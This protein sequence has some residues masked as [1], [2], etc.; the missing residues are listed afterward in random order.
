ML[1]KHKSVKHEKCFDV[2]KSGVDITRFIEKKKSTEREIPR[3]VNMSVSKDLKII[4]ERIEKEENDKTEP[5]VEIKQ[6]FSKVT[7]ANLQS[8]STIDKFVEYEQAL[9]KIK[10]HG[11]KTRIIARTE[12][13]E[14]EQVL[15]G[16]VIDKDMNNKEIQSNSPVPERQSSLLQSLMQNVHDVSVNEKC[17]ENISESSAEEPQNQN[18]VRQFDA[19]KDRLIDMREDLALTNK[20]ET[21][22]NK[23]MS[24]KTS[25]GLAKC[26]LLSLVFDEELPDFGYLE[27]EETPDKKKASKRSYSRRKVIAPKKLPPSKMM[28]SPR[29]TGLHKMGAS[30]FDI[31]AEKETREKVESVFKEFD[32]NEEEIKLQARKNLHA[33]SVTVTCIPFSEVEKYARGGID[34]KEISSLN[35]MPQIH[36]DSKKMGSELKAFPR[37][38]VRSYKNDLIS[39]NDDKSKISGNEDVRKDLTGCSIISESAPKNT[40]IIFKST[41]KNSSVVSENAPRN[42]PKKTLQRSSEQN[43][44][45]DKFYTAVFQDPG[46]NVCSNNIMIKSGPK[47]ASNKTVLRATQKNVKNHKSDTANIEDI[48]KDICGNSMLS[49]SGPKN[50]P[51][52]TIQS[53]SQKNFRNDNSDAAVLECPGKSACNNIISSNSSSKNATKKNIQKP[54]QKNNQTE[55]DTPGRLKLKPQFNDKSDT[56]AVKD[57]LKDLCVNESTSKKM[58]RN[59]A[60]KPSQKNCRKE[61]SAPALQKSKSTNKSKVTSSTEKNHSPSIRNEIVENKD[62]SALENNSSEVVKA[63]SSMAPSAPS[64]NDNAALI[65]SSILTKSTRN[66]RKVKKSVEF[67]EDFDDK[68]D[69]DIEVDFSDDEY[70]PGKG[71]LSPDENEIEIHKGKKEGNVS[72]RKKSSKKGAV[73]CDGMKN[74][75]LK[76]S[77]KGGIK[78]EKCRKKASEGKPKIAPKGK[79]RKYSPK[80]KSRKNDKRTPEQDGSQ[81]E[82]QNENIMDMPLIMPGRGRASQKKKRKLRV[83]TEK[84][85]LD[86]L[87]DYTSD[88]EESEEQTGTEDEGDG[89][90]KSKRKKRKRRKLHGVPYSVTGNWY[91]ASGYLF[92]ITNLLEEFARIESWRFREFSSCWQ[93]CNF[94]LIYR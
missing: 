63:E 27:G 50:A 62:E 44:K 34:S 90:P 28:K 77:T 23:F 56:T 83:R 1:L 30:V 94:S 46:K 17:P 73:R 13:E 72:D 2:A 66:R 18:Q 16:D 14:K 38:R 47:D 29:N 31:S 25:S 67:V 5:E 65:T 40:S 81:D 36:N 49:K 19:S 85:F 92:D 80:S 78:R 4:L 7:S 71:E 35:D 43:S 52:R 12:T 76:V 10:T 89:G 79:P 87:R 82:N 21:N 54:S 39:G 55:Q 57:P 3:I 51:K 59:Y 22:K 15:R 33:L 24:N 45:N 32:E 70:I 74:Q 6:E 9:R 11:K 84:S 8:A 64:E 68:S 37:R 75:L 41:Q 48:G 58:P 86:E 42:A 88:E 20:N 69:S 91:I 93:K 60:Q 26:K 61:R 53:P